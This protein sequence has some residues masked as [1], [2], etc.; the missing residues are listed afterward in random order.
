MMFSVKNKKFSDEPVS[1][2]SKSKEGH[3]ARTAAKGTTH[4][5][6]KTGVS[7]VTTKSPDKRECKTQKR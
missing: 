7:A 2:D 1:A 6:A 4:Q 5:P 3:T